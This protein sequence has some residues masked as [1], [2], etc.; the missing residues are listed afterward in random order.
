M[1]RI[2][3][4][5]LAS[6]D[7]IS[8]ALQSSGYRADFSVQSL[9]EIDRFFDEHS[10]NGAAKPGGLLSE[11]LGGRI[12]ALGSY[13]GEVIRRQVGGDWIGDESDPEAEM[14]VMLRLP[15]GGLCWPIQRAMKRFG[16]GSEDSIAFWGDIAIS[17]DKPQPAS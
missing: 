6:A 11:G 5:V 12:F 16:N 7:W 3:D 15:D 13:A 9:R 10:Q 17:H 8:C 2:I 1:G 14:N 4:D